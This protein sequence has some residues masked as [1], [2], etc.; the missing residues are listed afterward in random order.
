MLLPR[1]RDIASQLLS[2]ISDGGDREASPCS[3]S[4][5]WY[6]LFAVCLVLSLLTELISDP[7]AWGA[8]RLLPPCPLV[9][10]S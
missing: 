8:S 3:S 1:E 7:L 9:P 10:A 5:L 6:V 2:S 4:L